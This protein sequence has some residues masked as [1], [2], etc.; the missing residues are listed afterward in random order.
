MSAHVLAIPFANFARAFAILNP[1]R[2]VDDQTNN[3]LRLCAGRT[4]D[5]DYIRQR[6]IKL[7]DGGIDSVRDDLLW[8][9]DRPKLIDATITLIDAKGAAL[10]RVT[11]YTAMRS[12]SAD[13]DR[14]LLNG[15]P[16]YLRL[17]LAQNF[18]PESHLAAPSDA[19]LRRE[20]D[21][22]RALGFNGVR[23]HQKIE[24]PRFLAWCDRLG[25]VVWAEMPSAYEFSRT[26][27]SRVTRRSRC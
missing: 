26:T 5:S 1:V 22:V 17:V 18:W 3:L 6:T 9:P 4:Y 12:V 21:L 20:V 15:Q 27:V 11:S 2:N 10:D 14:L 13:L 16:Y 8:F 7:L 23:L 24:D 25:L 19:A